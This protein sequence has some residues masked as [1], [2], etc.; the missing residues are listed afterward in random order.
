MT[1]SSTSDTCVILSRSSISRQHRAQLK[2]LK[3]DHDNEQRHR[4]QA[5]CI[6]ENC[7]YKESSSNLVQESEVAN[8]INLLICEH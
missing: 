7:R 8:Q 5:C 1:T 3:I 2:S 4:A 6:A